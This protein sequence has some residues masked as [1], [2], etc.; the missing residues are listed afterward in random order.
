MKQKRRA[1]YFAIAA[2][3][4]TSSA[5]KSSGQRESNDGSGANAC[6][7]SP[8]ESKAS[9]HAEVAWGTPFDAPTSKRKQTYV[10]GNKEAVA[11]FLEY[12]TPAKALAMCDFTGP[13]LWGG[14]APT[15][16]DPDELLTKGGTLVMVSGRAIDDLAKQ[17]EA[18]GFVRWRA[19]GGNTAQGSVSSGSIDKEVA[20]ALDCSPKSADPLRAWC[21]VA[22]F[23]S[24]GFSPP[25]A[26][27]TYV[28][29]SVALTSGTPVKSAMLNRLSLSA[30]ILANGR[31][32]VISITPDNEDEKKQLLATAGLVSGV[33]KGEVNGPIRVGANLSGFL[34]G[35]KNKFAAGGAAVQA[36]ASK[37]AAYK[38]KNPSEIALV[39]G[40]VDAY[41]VIERASD[42]I[43]MNVFPVRPYGP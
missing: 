14:G 9:L 28:G 16:R 17:L 20:K 42:G 2:I 30:L 29:L 15:S 19:S 38:A 8:K 36:S 18:N 37:P 7:E 40:K 12:P 23:A 33:M 34:D 4:A 6:S 43:W 39:R 21:P 35:L 31:V 41:V 22:A 26:P 11:L 32:D 3:A 24:S 27:A 1:Y 10:C 5:C 13:Q 25:P